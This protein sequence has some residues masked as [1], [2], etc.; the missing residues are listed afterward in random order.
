MAIYDP[1]KPNHYMHDALGDPETCTGDHN[2]PG[3]IPPSTVAQGDTPLSLALTALTALRAE[4]IDNG[5]NSNPTLAKRFVSALH[6]A[7]AI[8]ATDEQVHRATGLGA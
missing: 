8:G 7:Y 4:I 3:A 1:N 6:F 5:T 2:H